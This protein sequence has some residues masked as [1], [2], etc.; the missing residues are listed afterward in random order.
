M[1]HTNH[2]ANAGCFKQ[3]QDQRRNTA[4]QQSAEAVALGALLKKYLIEEASKRPTWGNDEHETNA[5]ALA[6]KIWEY[7][8]DG[9]FPYVQFLADRILGKQQAQGSGDPAA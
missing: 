4:G 9:K 6:A 2:K 7:A 1:N 3:G 8:I 5:Q